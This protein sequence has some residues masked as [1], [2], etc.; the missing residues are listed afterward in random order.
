MKKNDADVAIF[1]NYEI[2]SSGVVKYINSFEKDHIDISD[3]DTKK[4]I[5]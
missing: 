4:Y 1:S 5:I 2:T 3:L